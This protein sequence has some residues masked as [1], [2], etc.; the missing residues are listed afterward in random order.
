MVVTALSPGPAET[1][2]DAAG[3]GVRGEADGG[4]REA[5][6]G[7]AD[8]HAVRPGTPKNTRPPTLPAGASADALYP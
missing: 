6:P 8:R 5:R 3:A 4:P 1:D 2:G 7:G